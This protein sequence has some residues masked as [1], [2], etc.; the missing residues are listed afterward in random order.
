MNWQ[1]TTPT[2]SNALIIPE[3]ALFNSCANIWLPPPK[4]SISQW[5]DK[6]RILS[7]EAC[8]TPG[9]WRTSRAE[10]QREIMNA[11]SNPFTERVIMMTSAQIGKTELLLNT[12]GYFADQQDRKSVV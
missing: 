6:S 4:L 5:A 3:E 8:A 10:Y 1:V 11:L 12:I 2:K 7:S 9:A